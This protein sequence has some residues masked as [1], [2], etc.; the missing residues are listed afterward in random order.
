MPACANQRLSA[1]TGEKSSQATP[2]YALG[3]LQSLGFLTMESWPE[4]PPILCYLLFFLYFEVLKIMLLFLFLIPGVCVL[5]CV[6]ACE[7]TACGGQKRLLELI[8]C[9]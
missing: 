9:S 2:G 1:C 3:F 6:C 4:V 7:C 8:V 5:M